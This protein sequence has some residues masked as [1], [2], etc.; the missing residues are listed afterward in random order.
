[1]PESFEPS[2]MDFWLGSVPPS[3]S[4]AKNRG[5]SSLDNHVHSSC[6]DTMPDM[7]RMHPNTW[8]AD[9]HQHQESIMEI[10]TSIG[11]VQEITMN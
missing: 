7:P 4:V 3:S 1:M 11:K 9:K 10:K 2:A 8:L 5:K 6:V